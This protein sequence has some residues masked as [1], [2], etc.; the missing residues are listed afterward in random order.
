MIFSPRL[1]NGNSHDSST[2]LL[3]VPIEQLDAQLNWKW[4]EHRFPLL[5][6]GRRY[7]GSLEPLVI[8]IN[9]VFGQDDSSVYCDEQSMAERYNEMVNFLHPVPADG[10]RFYIYFDAFTSSYMY[11]KRAYPIAFNISMGDNDHELFRY[12][13]NL[14]ID[15]PTVYTT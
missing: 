4:E 6:G 11:Y 10:F 9:G 5:D 14:K 7:D 12:S 3:P 8:P 13:L 1:V 2:L 15:D